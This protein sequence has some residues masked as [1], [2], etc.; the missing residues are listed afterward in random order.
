[1]ST[2]FIGPKDKIF[3]LSDHAQLLLGVSMGV[4]AGVFLV[5]VAVYFAR[6]EKEYEP[7]VMNELKSKAVD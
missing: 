6:K 7:V 2:L 1:M 3:R 4:A 5:L